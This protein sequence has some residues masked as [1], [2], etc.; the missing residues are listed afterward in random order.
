MGGE[1]AGD[2]LRLGKAG[3]AGGA[4]VPHGNV[5]ERAVFLAVDEV[6]RGGHVEVL[7][8]DARR[9]VP[10]GDQALGMRIG[11][12]L[13]Q[14][15]LDH[16]EN[17]RIGPDA[18]GQRDQRNGG[19]LGRPRESA[20]RVNAGR[21]DGSQVPPP[22]CSKGKYAGG[23]KKFA[24]CWRGQETAAPAASENSLGPTHFTVDAC[25]PLEERVRGVVAVLLPGSCLR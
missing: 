9:G 18:D 22:R 16:A 11:Q 10:H 5:F 14:D 24:N 21:K 8:I 13:Q 25:R 1:Q 17:R 20:Q 23:G 12:R 15:A 2:F 4:V 3:D 19:K 7:D 6:Q